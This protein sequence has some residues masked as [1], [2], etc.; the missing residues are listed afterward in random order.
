MHFL[1]S[2][3]SLFSFFHGKSPVTWTSESVK[4]NSNE[5][6]LVFTANIE[7]G[8]NIY[9]QYLKNDEGPV[10]TSITYDSKDGYELIGKNEETG[11]IKKIMDE[12]FG[13]E[14]IKIKHKGTFTQR[15]KVSN[16]SKPISGYIEF[17]CCNE[18]Q[19]LP[20]RQINFTID[21]KAAN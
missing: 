14:V 18:Q 11:E 4:I 6:N 10:R 7:D 3:L 16:L 5:Y 20:P 19:C 17:M 21:L 12:M 8:W 15:I 13:M 2:L 9:S 1:L